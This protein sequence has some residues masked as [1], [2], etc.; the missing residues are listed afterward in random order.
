[1]KWQRL[2]VLSAPV[3]MLAVILGS[4]SF[5]WA[6]TPAR[7]APAPSSAP[8]QAIVN[9]IVA[10]FPRVSGDV[11]EV[12]GTTVTLSVGKRDGVVP[13]LELSLF[14]EGRE[15]RHPKTGEVL[16]KTEKALGR[17]R[18]E[19]VAEAY[20]IGR[21]EPGAD[22]APGDLA[23]ISAGKQR[24]TVVPFTAGVRDAIVE[25]ALT[26]IVEGLGRSGRIQ[27]AMGDHVGVWV[28]QQ[29]IKPD[30]FLEGKGLSESASRFKVDNL[31]ALHFKT[32]DRKPYVDAR[33]FA[34]PSTT[35]VVASATF[36]PPSVRTA[37]RERFS[38][39]GDRLPPQAKQRSLLAR[40]LGGEL[41]AGSYSSGENSIPLKEIGR[42][43]FPVVAMDVSVSP[44]DQVPRLVM[45][46]G[47][48]IWLYRVVERA[49]EPEWT[50]DE[51]FTTPGRIISVQLADLDGDGVFEVVANRYHPDPNVLLT[52][53]VL[54]TKDGKPVTVVKNGND[55]LWAVD[56][57]GSGAKKTVWAQG[58]SRETFFRKGQAHR[59]TLK[60]DQLVRDV[61]VRVPS[62]FRATGATL[63][64]IAGKDMR[65]LV[66]VDEYQRLRV[67]VGTEDTWR[68]SS[69]VGGGSYLRLELLKAGTTSRSPRTEFINFE[70]VPVAVDLDGDGVEEVLVPQN[71]LEGH[72]G[73]L[74]RGPAGYRFQSV[75]SGFEGTITALGA[76]PGE[77]P[78]TLIAAVVRFTTFLKGAAETQI[79]MTTGDSS[80]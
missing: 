6:Q 75:N 44:K 2:A 66:F 23:R 47:E 34:L 65:A 33:F 40:I 22:V 70:P 43:A 61:A 73:I 71:Q 7:Q 59:V 51:R 18:V 52:S 62:S 11:V 68:S 15:L 67:T 69:P 53:F 35:P 42:F 37:P 38:S 48:K 58:F 25:A 28:T 16:G 21:V 32:V 63:A 8:L 26:D 19:E 31:L 36:V 57:D 10:L 50:Y 17:V 9:Q 72:I 79:I 49:L 78:P 76:I 45:T 14:R 13:G 64:S 46:D 5:P 1:M 12:Q 41:E 3:V 4:A 20:S 29:G 55:I 74:F 30:E 39:G 27:V 77:N 24:V 56:A 54:G 60:G 80:P